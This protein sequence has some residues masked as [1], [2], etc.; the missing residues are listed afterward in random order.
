MP[1][2][3]VASLAFPAISGS[4]ER[5][6]AP[7]ELNPEERA[8]FVGVVADCKAGHFKP[9]DAALLAAY[10]R[11]ILT[12]REA[13]TRLKEDGRVIDGKPSPWISI[14]TAANKS[15]LAFARALRLSPLGRGPNH[16]SRPSRALPQRSLSVYEIMALESDDDARA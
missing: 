4:S 12:E 2:R 6:R 13:S 1:R 9:S 14:W 15:M 5:L 10:V 8:L 11:T 3:S 16:P 7:A